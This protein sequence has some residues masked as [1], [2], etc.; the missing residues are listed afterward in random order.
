MGSVNPATD[1][2]KTRC[3]MEVYFQDILTLPVDV[4]VIPANPRVLPH[5]GTGIEKAMYEAAGETLYTERQKIGELEPGQCAMTGPGEYKYAGWIIHAVSPYD[6]TRDGEE[7]QRK[8]RICYRNIFGTIKEKFGSDPATISIPL[9]ASG[10]NKCPVELAMKIQLQETID[11]L[12]ENRSL[13]YTLKLVYSENGAR[14]YNAV[15]GNLINNAPENKIEMLKQ[16]ERMNAREY[17]PNL[18]KHGNIVSKEL[19][20]RINRA[21][22]EPSAED[23]PHFSDLLKK[24]IERFE[25]QNDLKSGKYVSNLMK[26]G[27]TADKGTLSRLVNGVSTTPKRDTVYQIAIALK[28]NKAELAQLMGS[29]GMLP[30]PWAYKT[31]RIGLSYIENSNGDVAGYL[32]ETGREKEVINRHDRTCDKHYDRNPADEGR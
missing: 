10:A 26:A 25:K 24:Y 27:V 1:G 6:L 12:M 5:G 21:M 29:M 20:T 23:H 32:R 18:S 14:L 17:P 7:G 28:L 31:D 22:R 11:F 8:L 2:E 30:A 19:V 16:Q 9:L 13:P 3:R 15:F 4:I